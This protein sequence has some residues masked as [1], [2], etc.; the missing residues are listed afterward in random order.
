M[1]M[2]KTARQFLRFLAVGLLNTAFGYA[3]FAILIVAGVPP[4]PALVLTYVFGIT[5]NFFTTGRLV[6]RTRR[7]GPFLRFVAAYVVIYLFNLGLYRLAEGAGASPLVAQALC[8]PVVAV[9]SFVIFKLHV[10]RDTSA[11]GEEPR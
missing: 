9:F 4:M 6:F 3:V 1:A 8:L 5:F 2:K 7:G 10:F 11:R